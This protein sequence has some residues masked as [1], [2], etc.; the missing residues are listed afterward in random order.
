MVTEKSWEDFRATGLLLFINTFLHI[1]GWSVVCQLDKVTG[2]VTNVY[3][4]RV[5]FR[6]FDYVDMEEAYKKVTTHMR[7]NAED[8]EAEVSSETTG[9]YR[10][11]TRI[12][13][14]DTSRDPDDI[15]EYDIK[16]CISKSEALDIANKYIKSKF[17]DKNT[18]LKEQ[19]D[20]TY[21]AL[22]FKSWGEYI[23][24]AHMV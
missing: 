3:P 6:G 5:K 12:N 24:V 1:F 15:R 9:R 14:A 19:A 11:Y 22:N 20:G 10:V 18:E 8:L 16:T 21:S 4:A 17:R 7:Q 13:Y 2:K 23:I